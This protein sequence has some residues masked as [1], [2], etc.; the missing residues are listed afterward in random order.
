MNLLQDF[1]YGL[2]A[3]ARKPG[4]AVTAILTLALGIGANVAVFSI[5][6]ALIL[7]PYPFPDLDRLVL[8]R[9][10][11]PKVLNPAKI[12]LADFVDL[13]RDTSIFHGLAAF[14]Q[15]DSNLTGSGDVQTVSA[16][17][18]STNFFDTIG[19]QPQLGRQFTAENAESGRDAVVI[20]S[21]GFW[22]RRFHGD[23]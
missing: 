7:R 22:Q 17:T 18:V 3:L 12:P 9:G 1:R 8:L 16:V 6:N 5:V 10:T 14:R 19:V 15:Y 11:G 2:R 21:Y 13:G 23:S 4:F 20:L